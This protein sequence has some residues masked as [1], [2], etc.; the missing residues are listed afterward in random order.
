[1]TIQSAKIPLI[2]VICVLMFVFFAGCA[3]IGTD[4]FE[5]KWAGYGKTVTT[6]SK[7][8]VVC[9]IKKNGSNY[10]VQMKDEMLDNNITASFKGGRVKAIWSDMGLLSNAS[11][12]AK[13]NLLGINESGR[14]WNVTFNEK[15]KTLLLPSI[16]NL[17]SCTLHKVTDEELKSME[18]EYYDE[19]TDEIKQRHPSITDFEESDL[20]NGE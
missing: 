16:D 14:V 19:Y 11:G 5:G 1:M 6:Q 18:K 13:D 10:I 8:L 2:G 7:V 9:E 17:S 4:K 15:D 12:V 3:S 20:R